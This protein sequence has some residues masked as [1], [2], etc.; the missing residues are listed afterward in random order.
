M[1]ANIKEYNIKDNDIAIIGLA[2]Y[3]SEAD[4]LQEFWDILKAGKSTV[5]TIPFER[6][7]NGA[8]YSE[9]KTT[10]GTY[11]AR[12]GSFLKNYDQFEPEFFKISNDEANK[13][14]PQERL[15]LKTAWNCIEDAG[16]NYENFHD[17][18]VGVFVG[19]M[20]GHYHLVSLEAYLNGQYNYSSSTLS[21]IAN[22][23]SYCLDLHGPSMAVDSMCSSSLSALHLACNSILNEDCECCIVGGVNLSLHFYKYLVLCDNAFLSKDGLCRSFGKD[24][25]GYVPGEGV[26][27]ILIK[28]LKK[29]L[30]DKDSIYG[31]IKGSS[32]NSGGRTSGFTVPSRKAQ[33][34][35]ITSVLNNANLSA[36]QVNYIEAHGTG[37][38]IGDRIEINAL[39][40]AFSDLLSRVPVGSV[41]SNIGHLESASGMAAITK[42]LLQM[43]Y[44]KI[45]PSLHSEEL[46][47]YI[48]FVN[49]PFYIPQEIEEWDSD[50]KKM[51][52]CISS[53]GAG[54]SNANVIIEEF[55][56]GPE[57]NKITFKEQLIV[58][59]ARKQTSLIKICTDLSGFIRRNQLDNKDLIRI[60]YT[61]QT[62]RVQNDLRVAFL[63]SSLEELLNK[64]ELFI[65]KE[66]ALF[67]S[68]R[69][70]RNPDNAVDESSL[71]NYLS[72]KDLNVLAR[73]WVNGAN[74]DWKLLY[75]GQH[76]RKINLPTYA[77]DDRRCWIAETK[78][79]KAKKET[80]SLEAKSIE[81]K[82]TPRT[83]DMVNDWI[84][85]QIVNFLKIDMMDIDSSTAKLIDIGFSSIYSLRLLNEINQMYEKSFTLTDIGYNP[86]VELNSFIQ[87][88]AELLCNDSSK[89]EEKKKI[90]DT[91]DYQK[92]NLFPP[93]TEIKNLEMKEILL[94]GATGV[95]GGCLLTYFIDN[96]EYH[97]NCLVRSKNEE[98]GFLRVLNMADTYEGFG[99]NREE[100]K[101]R[102]SIVTGDVAKE[103]FGLSKTEYQKLT[104][105]IDLVIHCAA[106]TSLSGG[107]EEVKEANVTGT[108]NIID[109]TLETKQK[110]LVFMS[111]HMFMGDIWYK[112]KDRL[113]T[114]TDLFLNQNFEHMGYQQSK[115]ESEILIREAY[116]KGLKWIIFRTGNIMGKSTDGSYPL[117][118]TST[119]GLYYEII[120]T[121][122]QSKL[123]LSTNYYFDITPLDYLCK[124]IIALINRGILY[125]TY[126]VTNP[127]Y[128]TMNEFY[129]LLKMSGC[130]FKIYKEDE[131]F[132][133][134]DYYREIS[135]IV[136]LYGELLKANPVFSK[137]IYNSS[138]VNCDYTA[139]ILKQLGI[140][141][142]PIDKK[143]IETYLNYCYEEKFLLNK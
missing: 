11:Y 99:D 51:C 137:T 27:A 23:V 135:P 10:P 77:F 35:L 96:T 70:S 132:T 115:F 62:G 136:S 66:D 5:G 3:Y 75:D 87:D 72:A 33:E 109:F 118:K 84:W 30:E 114:E 142:P 90:T 41:K 93:K 122:L 71:P 64:L 94:T 8:Y 63:V 26:G 134:F 140:S 103:R 85:S 129:E 67:Y 97:I 102:I 98:E 108:Q 92:E 68:S 22:R 125:E 40:S 65:Q 13:M 133:Y 24:G 126:H 28:P 130:K 57:E 47:P 105:N 107:Y 91:L 7:D 56:E 111:T 16:Y 50:T 128:I 12:W 15:F 9:D 83:R 78:N 89:P 61:L 59:S 20:W 18:K 32:V 14:D 38:A 58:L 60:A 48:D 17:S 95:L 117:A 4:N 46:N 19:A 39:K 141:C 45:V 37:T 54:G 138:H 123:A 80:K 113:I 6:W 79:M 49:S 1:N 55:K 2:G 53:F 131:F 121:T 31:V 52:A 43:K 143:L 139:G 101:R 116:K 124:S 73:A 76:P 110:F 36:N 69:N 21:S 106:K 112:E 74:I 82:F 86:A 44:K 25:D 42:V 127:H 119:P 120:K 81:A 100:L 29:A 88:I 104:E 34:D